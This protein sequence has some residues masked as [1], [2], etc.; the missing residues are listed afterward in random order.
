[1]KDYDCPLDF[2]YYCAEHWAG[3]NNL[4]AMSTFILNRA[5]AYTSI[6]GK[7]GDISNLFQYKWYIGATIE[8]TRNVFLLTEKSWDKS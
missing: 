1:M 2:W 6:I 8:S 4:T 7:D 5:N 3:I